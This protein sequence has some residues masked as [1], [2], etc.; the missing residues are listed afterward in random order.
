MTEQ[1]KH[2]SLKF[3]LELA[4]MIQ[5]D[6]QRIVDDFGADFERPNCAVDTAISLHIKLSQAHGILEQLRYRLDAWKFV[7]EM[8][9][10]EKQEI[11][12]EANSLML[13][14]IANGE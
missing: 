8:T 11:I 10:K 6:M 9:P 7:V 12:D 2:P 14:K 5:A 13:E 4:K 1:V 3:I